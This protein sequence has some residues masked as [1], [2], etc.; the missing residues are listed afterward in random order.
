MC[1]SNRYTHTEMKLKIKG[2]GGLVAY[3]GT[4]DLMLLEK[5]LDGK[6]LT[7]EEKASLKPHVTPEYAQLVIRAMSYQVAKEICAL[8]AVFSGHVDAIVLTGGI[9]RDKRILSEIKTRVAWIAPIMVFPGG[10]EMRALRDAA[11]RVLTGQEPLK[12]YVRN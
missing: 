7:P 11:A 8:T 5:Y 1:W 12:V 2:R 9:V 6:P 4:S 10:D 3:L